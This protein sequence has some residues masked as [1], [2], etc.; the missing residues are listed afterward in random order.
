MRPY[1]E[2]E[3]DW[4]YL[5]KLLAI[6]IAFATASHIVLL[7]TLPGMP[8]LGRMVIT[9]ICVM[10]LLSVLVRRCPAG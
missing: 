10:G 2:Y 6:A 9:G 8:L 4:R 3:I 7:L 1:H 5:G